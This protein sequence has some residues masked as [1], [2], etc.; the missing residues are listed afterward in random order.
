M[1]LGAPLGSEAAAPRA[2]PCR[3][4]PSCPSSSSSSSSAPPRA[5]PRGCWSCACSRRGGPGGPCGAPPPPACRLQFRL[6]LRPPGGRGC[7]LGV[8]Q[9]PPGPPPAPGA[10]RTLRLP[11]A[12]PWPGSV[13]LV[14][15]SWRLQESGAPGPP[16]RLVS[17]AESRPRLSPGALAGGGGGW[18][19]LRG[20]PALPL[21]PLPPAAAG[22]AAAP[23][24]VSGGSLRP[25]PQR[26]R[27]RRRLRGG[28]CRLAGALPGLLPLPRWSLLSAAATAQRDDCSLNPCA[29]GGIVPDGANA[30]TCTCTLGF[31]GLRCRRRRAG[32]CAK[33]NLQEYGGTCWPHFRPVCACAP[34]FMGG[35]RFG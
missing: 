9:S 12:F 20:A 28:Q 10:P 25:P 34:G 11:L 6:C 7:S 35:R 26:L 24:G 14:V 23:P 13:S 4:S 30:F 17:R 21:P 2:R 19:A 8:A 32:A 22:A 16:L 3:P 15:E 5:A 1:G 27:H 29:H 31:A 18:A 33:L